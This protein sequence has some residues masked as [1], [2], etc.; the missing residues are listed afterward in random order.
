MF[1][2]RPFA[3]FTD[4]HISTNRIGVALLV[5]ALLATSAPSEA[6][7]PVTWGTPTARAAPA[8]E[9]DVGLEVGQR[10]PDFTLTTLNGA[11][12]T[13]ADL[14]AQNKPFILYFFATW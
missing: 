8:M 5:A 10:A 6:T 2:C 11:P 12:L 9:A 7:H 4:I 13:S 14:L 1:R 3:R